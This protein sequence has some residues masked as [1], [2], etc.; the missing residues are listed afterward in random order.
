MTTY[1]ASCLSMASTRH[2]DTKISHAVSMEVLR[3][4][5]VLDGLTRF[6]MPLVSAA[7]GRPNPD[8]A[9]TRAIFLADIT[10]IGMKWVWDLK[11]WVQD[12]SKLLSIYYPE[13]LDLAL[14]SSSCDYLNIRIL[15]LYF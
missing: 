2:A 13:I 7:P 8:Q 1:R 11:S 14:V 10:G 12:L 4:S 3:S 15:V 6:T 9:I 5:A